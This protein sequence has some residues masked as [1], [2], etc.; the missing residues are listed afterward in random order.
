MTFFKLDELKPQRPAKGVALKAFTGSKMSMV[1][2]QLEPG[3]AVPEHTHP[4]EQMGTVLQGAVEL[5]IGD[6]KQIVAQGGAYHIPSG[7]PHGGRCLDQPAKV[8]EMFAPPRED[9]IAE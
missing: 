1:L 6:E 8:L 5:T 3:A 7:Q 4:H 2:F 9:L